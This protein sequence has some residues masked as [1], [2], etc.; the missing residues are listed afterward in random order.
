MIA[1][2]AGLHI[3]GLPYRPSARAAMSGLGRRREVCRVAHLGSPQHTEW[4]SACHHA[5]LD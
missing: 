4:L 3:G 1:Q 5:R 2:G